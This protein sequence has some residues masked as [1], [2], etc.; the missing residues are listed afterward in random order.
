MIV[1]IDP[2]AFVEQT[3]ANG[4]GRATELAVDTTHKPWHWRISVARLD[5]DAVFSSLPGVQRQFAP[6]NGPV[7]LLFASGNA[8]RQVN[9][10]QT[11]H[12][13]GGDAPTCHVQD[14]PAYAI[15]LMLRGNAQGELLLRPLVGSML[16]TPQTGTRW[17]VYMLTGQAEL[18]TPETCLALTPGSAAWV[19][20]RAGSRTI[21]EGAGEI[22]VIQ[23]RDSSPYASSEPNQR[24]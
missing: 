2:S 23:L 8:S 24:P 10:L 14:T 6:L 21:I 1:P 18:A 3:W 19:Q 11:L 20:P 4:N 15:N 22:A 7:K 12:F 13:D 17:F 5:G 16:L 9:R